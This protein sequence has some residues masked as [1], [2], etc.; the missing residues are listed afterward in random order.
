MFL[1]PF[2]V[3]YYTTINYIKHVMDL[4][5]KDYQLSTNY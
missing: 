5:L 3:P 1:P 2:P 4:F